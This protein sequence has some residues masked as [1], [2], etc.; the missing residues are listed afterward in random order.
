MRHAKVIGVAM[1]AALCAA[2]AQGTPSTL[3]WIPSTDIQA[4]K[5][6]HGG[7]DNYSAHG[8]GAGSITDYGLTYGFLGGRAEVGADYF[9]GAHDPLYF[10]AKFRVAAENARTPAFAV[11]AMN[12]G[13]KKDAT[14]YNMVYGL[15]AKTLGPARLTLGYC[16]GNKAALGTDPNVLLAGVDGYLTK[17]RRWWGAVDY[18]GGRNAFGALNVGVSYA[19]TDKISVIVGYDAYNNSALRDTVTTQLDVNF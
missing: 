9:G 13:T 2:T 10:N 17:D 11:G 15:I 5:T 3:I 6:W 1:L 7:I 19:F 12:W 18:Q 14:D 4:D 8:S 16:H